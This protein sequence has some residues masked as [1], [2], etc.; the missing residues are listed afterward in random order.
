MGM[1]YSITA[2]DEELKELLSVFEKLDNNT[3]HACLKDLFIEK[4]TIDESTGEIVHNEISTKGM[5]PTDFIL[6][7]TPVYK[8]AKEFLNID[9]KQP[10]EDFYFEDTENDDRE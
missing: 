9:I 7:Y 10:N 2:V 6:Y 8:W 3:V 4:L 5:S 1:R